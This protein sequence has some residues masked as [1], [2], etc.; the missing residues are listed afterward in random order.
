MLRMSDQK[1]RVSF[2]EHH[3]KQAAP[4]STH[5]LPSWWVMNLMSSTIVKCCLKEVL[6]YIL[7]TND[8]KGRNTLIRKITVY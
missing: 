6:R 2:Q 3:P 8:F 1:R 5:F 4:S 7:S